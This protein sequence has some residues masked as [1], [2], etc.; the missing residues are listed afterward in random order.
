MYQYHPYMWA[1]IASAAL[2]ATL[3]ASIL[4]RRRNV[5]GAKSFTACLF[6]IALWSLANALEIAGADLPTKLFWANVQYVSY[7][8]LPVA[9]LSLCLTFSDIGRRMNVKK[10]LLLAVFPSIILALVWTDRF[11]GLIRYDFRL[12]ESGIV[13]VIAKKF[14]PFFFA[15]ALYSYLLCVFGWAALFRAV[16]S[17]TAVYRRQTAALL[18][19]ITFIIVPNVLYLLGYSPVP[20]LDLTPFF[21]IPAAFFI[22]WAIIRYK[23]FDIVPLAWAAVIRTLDAGVMVLDL[24]NRVLYINPAF[25]GMAVVQEDAVHYKPVEDV[26]AA[27]PE[28]A[29]FCRSPG[30]MPSEFSRGAEGRRRFYEA[31]FYPLA[32]AQSPLGRLVVVNDVT[33]R[34]EIQQEAQEQ[35]W[36]L[37]INEERERMA[38]DLHDN[39]AQMLGFINYQASGIHH[40]MQSA[41]VETAAEELEKLVSVTQLA[42][43]DI[44]RYIRRAREASSMEKSLAAALQ[45]EIEN[46]EQ[47]T[48]IKVQA[49]IPPGFTGQELNPQVRMNLSYIF[50][51]ALVNIAKHAGAGRVTL[52]LAMAED[53]LQAVIEDDGR[54]F[55]AE[56]LSGGPSRGFGLS[57][58]RERARE[59]GAQIR[60]ES[61]VGQGCRITLRAPIEERRC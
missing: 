27:L 60:I 58:M 7:C 42:Y 5:K 53:H 40:E 22:T 44:R 21:F 20:G 35:Q 47:M 33:R 37:A 10:I 39:L 26:C 15:H 45:G 61:A 43:D 14:G 57:I 46:F 49:D 16:F 18:L 1:G 32:D 17:K 29:Y 56:N 51:E 12:E 55:D 9:T 6:F 3:G 19:G 8:Y 38:R 28:L 4:L 31:W 36:R 54:G 48:G 2:T 50:R 59:I 41:G 24:E 30:M 13:T 25:A 23:M 52:S 34:K 11:H